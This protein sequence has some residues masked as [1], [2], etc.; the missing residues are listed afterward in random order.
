MKRWLRV[1]APLALMLVVVGA[2]AL[3]FHG[4]GM[5]IPDDAKDMT[6]EEA[7]TSVSEGVGRVIAAG[8]KAAQEVD[9]IAVE[10]DSVAVEVTDAP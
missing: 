1:L 8:V 6:L 5:M 4:V 9:S 2:I 10:V 7:A 3:L